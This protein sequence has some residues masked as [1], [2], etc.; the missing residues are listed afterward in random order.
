MSDGVLADLVF[1]VNN[2]RVVPHLLPILVAVF[3]SE[4]AR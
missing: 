4:E 2:N 1:P 3:E